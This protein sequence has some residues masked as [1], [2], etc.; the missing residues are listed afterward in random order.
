MFYLMNCDNNVCFNHQWC[1]WWFVLILCVKAAKMRLIEGLKELDKND[2]KP[3]KQQQIHTV[4]QVL[5]C[6][7][8]V[9]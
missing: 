2:K 9:A 6:I 8:Q 3:E 1:V 5:H 4:S 7:I